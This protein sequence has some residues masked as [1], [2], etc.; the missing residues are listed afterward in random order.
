MCA[1][2]KALRCFQHIVSWCQNGRTNTDTEQATCYT[3]T[4]GKVVQQTEGNNC[5]AG[6]L[7]QQSNCESAQS[8][9]GLLRVPVR[10]LTRLAEDGDPAV[11]WGG[12]STVNYPLQSSRQERRGY[13]HQ[14]VDP[15]HGD[16]SA[17]AKNSISPLR[18]RIA[19]E[20]TH[21]DHTS[22]GRLTCRA[23]PPKKLSV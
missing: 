14:N 20:E 18:A 12:V 16:T 22:G 4:W 17:M 15:K 5:I 8:R 2:A 6:K 10:G 19:L 3:C 7:T 9:L 1:A 13:H 11:S 21:E 23:E